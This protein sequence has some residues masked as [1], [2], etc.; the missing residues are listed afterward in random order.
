MDWL[1][2]NLGNLKR[3]YM[4]EIAY[5]KWSP[6]LVNKTVPFYF[7]RVQFLT[8]GNYGLSGAVRSHLSALRPRS[9]L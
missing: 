1:E 2:T 6:L 5:I 3:L 7:V 8:D 9:Y 4:L